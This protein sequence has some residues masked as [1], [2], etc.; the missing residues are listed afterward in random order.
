MIKILVLYPPQLD[1]VG[2]WRLFRPLDIMR[3]LYPGVFDITYKSKDL[4]FG[5][6][7]THDVIITRRPS[8]QSAGYHV[9]LLQMARQPGIEKPVIFDEDDAVMMLPDTHDL[10]HEFSGEAIRKQYVESLKCASMYWFSTPAFMESIPTILGEAPKVPGFVIPN[11][12]FP[13]DLPD[14]PAPDMGLFGWQ[15]KAIQA[16]DVID[17]WDWYE[18]NKGNPVI[19]QWAFFG[20][21]PS[22]RHLENASGPPIPYMPNVYSFVESF[23][24]NP[25]LGMYGINAMWKPLTPCQFN[26]HKSNIN[27]LVASIG[28]G[29]CITNYAGRPGWEFASSEVLPY[30][31]ACDLWRAAKEDIISRY[32]ILETAR[33]RAE[34]I[35]SLVPQFL[36]K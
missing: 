19:K 33:M 12:V 4:T 20:W 13:S 3:K 27:Y 9:E 8:G 26:G 6:I 1:N 35:L 24:K 36:S 30:A 7:V 34:S 32:N 2:Y 11:A 31:D 10:Y 17:G 21:K 22:L 16:H 15:G 14:E 25:K 28:G 23:K 29:Y 18:E 5:D